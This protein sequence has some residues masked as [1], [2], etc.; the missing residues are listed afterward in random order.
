[1]KICVQIAIFTVFN[2]NGNSSSLCQLSLGKDGS[3][4]FHLPF[5]SKCVIFTSCETHT[6]T[7]THTQLI[8]N[9]THQH[10]EGGVLQTCWCGAEAYEKC[11]FLRALDIPALVKNKF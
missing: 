1:M 3:L 2:K 7:H 9:Q 10:T 5:P 4:L 6:H 11:T 8:N